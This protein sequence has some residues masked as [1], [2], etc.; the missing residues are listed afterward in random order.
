MNSPTTRLLYFA[1]ALVCICP[2]AVSINPEGFAALRLAS[3]NAS[4]EHS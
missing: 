4:M 1:L 2:F 3:G